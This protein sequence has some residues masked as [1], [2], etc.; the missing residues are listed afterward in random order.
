MKNIKDLIIIAFALLLGVVMYFALPTFWSIKWNHD[1]AQEKK[2]YEEMLALMN[3]LEDRELEK[4]GRY[5]FQVLSESFIV[6]D[7]A[8]GTL[9]MFDPATTNWFQIS[10]VPKATP[11]NIR[12]WNPKTRRIEPSRSSAGE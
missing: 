1:Q 12:K 2:E 3:Q 4:P 7:T 5:T 11:E 6:L 8:R 9:W 10:Q